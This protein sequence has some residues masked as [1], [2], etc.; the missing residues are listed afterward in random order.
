MK[1]MGINARKVF[2]EKFNSE[3][4]YEILLN[5]YDTLIKQK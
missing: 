2:E 5:V 3:K 1:K 4:N